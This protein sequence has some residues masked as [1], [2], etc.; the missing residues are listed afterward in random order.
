MLRSYDSRFRPT[1]RSPEIYLS[2]ECHDIVGGEPREVA[3][4][5]EDFDTAA[6]ND[7]RGD[8]GGSCDDSFWSSKSQGRGLLIIATPYRV[9]G[10]VAKSAKVFLPVIAQLELLHRKG[11]VHGDIRAFNTVFGE[12]DD[13]GWLIDFDFGGQIGAT[14]YP[15]GYRRNLDDGTRIGCEK[16]IIEKWHDWYALGKL[17]FTVHNINLP[18]GFSEQHE[19]KLGRMERFWGIKGISME[20]SESE[21]EELKSFLREID[22]QGWQVTPS[23]AFQAALKD[24]STGPIRG[25]SFP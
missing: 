13:E 18:I 21:K 12:Q 3:K 24:T 17:I 4:F 9:G 22:E 5:P 15:D 19:L 2:P 10:H 16:A 14:Y 25:G 8:N 7:N 11:F 20:P 23:P 1:N 6:F